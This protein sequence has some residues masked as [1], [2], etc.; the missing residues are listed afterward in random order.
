MLE[1][2]EEDALKLGDYQLNRLKAAV[3][4][5]HGLVCHYCDEHGDTVD[6]VVACAVMVPFVALGLWLGLSDPKGGMADDAR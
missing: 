3:R 2:V 6:H 1:P 5:V 4:A